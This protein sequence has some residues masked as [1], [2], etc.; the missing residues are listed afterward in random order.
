MYFMRFLNF[1]VLFWLPNHPK[2]HYPY[3]LRVSWITNAMRG[4]GKISMNFNLIA[5]HSLKNSSGWDSS[6]K[7]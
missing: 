1:L 6:Q 3:F 2:P 5:E 4:V 7:S